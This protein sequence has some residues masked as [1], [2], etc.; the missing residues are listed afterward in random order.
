M[1]DNQYFEIIING[2][3]YSSTGGNIQANYS[4]TRTTP[5]VDKP[6]DYYLA[7]A[8][9]TIPLNLLPLFIFPVIPNQANPNLS[10]FKL[11]LLYKNV[12]YSADLIW[13]TQDP[14]IVPPV[15][16]KAKQ[17]ITP[18]Y[19]AYEWYHLIK[20]INVTLAT[21]YDAAKAANPAD[22][23]FAFTRKPTLIFDPVSGLFSFV[24]PKV[25]ATFTSFDQNGSTSNNVYLAANTEFVEFMNGFYYN[26]YTRFLGPYDSVYNIYD[27]G[28]NNFSGDANFITFIQNIN[29]LGLINSLKRIVVTSSAI[30]C[31]QEM[32]P[33]TSLDNTG[34]DLSQGSLPIIADF[35]VQNSDLNSARSIAYV[36]PNFYRFIDLKSTTPL[37]RINCSVFWSD[38]ENNLFPIEVG[39]N[40]QISIKLAFIRK[41]IANIYNINGNENRR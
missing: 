35:I 20:I 36:L 10:P 4:T 39:T 9:M 30:P 3:S 38:N 17:V 23:N 14:N 8:R 1:T 19:F 12:V 31:N 6:S 40:Q 22:P 11:S 26:E 34:L 16:D 32:I 28:N 37:S 15:Q 29:T 21:I 7:V 24:V 41:S 2:P 27:F 18:Y 5:I 25:W 13:V 33:S